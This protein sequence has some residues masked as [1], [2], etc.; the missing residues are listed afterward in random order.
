MSIGPKEIFQHGWEALRSKISSQHW[1]AHNPRPRTHYPIENEMQVLGHR[2]ARGMAPENTMA[3]F[4]IC[5]NLGVGF[6]LDTQLCFSGEP[7]VFHDDTLERCTNG[8][9]RLKDYSLTQLKKL[10]AGSHFSTQFRGEAIPTLGEV[11]ET[12]GKQV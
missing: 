12:Y 10:D 3:G 1:I 2:G 8:S 6:E 11:L 9:G 4:E 7:V 5:A